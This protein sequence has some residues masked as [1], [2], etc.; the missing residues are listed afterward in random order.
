[1]FYTWQKYDDIGGVYTSPYSAIE[2]A[3]I[4]LD[5]LPNITEG[6]LQSK[7]VIKGN[8]LFIR[9]ALHFAIAQLFAKPYVAVTANNDL[10]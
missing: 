6:D 8:G 5:A 7:N 9:G 2:Y 3:N 1:M 10:G 4:V